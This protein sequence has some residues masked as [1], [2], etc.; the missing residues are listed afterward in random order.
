[1]EDP[2]MERLSLNLDSVELQLRCFAGSPQRAVVLLVHGA[3]EDGRVFH[4]R[5]DQGLVGVLTAA[6][7]SVYVLDLRGHG[8]SQPRLQDAAAEVTQHRVITEDLPAALAL[9]QERHRQQPLFA[10]GHGWGGVWL[11]SALIRRPDL[12][13][14]I[15]GLL[16]FAVRRGQRHGGLFTRFASALFWRRLLPLLGHAKGLIPAR[17]MAL[18]SADE[19]TAIYAANLAWMRGEWRDLEDGFDYASAIAELA[20]P[21]SL[22]LAGE[23]DRQQ[24]HIGDVRDFA[25][26]LGPH[27]AQIVLLQKGQGCSRRYGHNDLLTHPQAEVDHFPLVLSWLEQHLR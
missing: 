11:A 17:A 22:Y 10:G 25:R 13:A 9:L 3:L 6:G 16:Q 23:T 8:A 14:G 27:D 12:L 15:A 5:R 2:A 26:E 7:H 19:S 21:P 18:G 1:M 24:G 4:P 20:W